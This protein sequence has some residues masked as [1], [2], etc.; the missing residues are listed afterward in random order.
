M[1]LSELSPGASLPKMELQAGRQGYLLCVE[2]SVQLT[3]ADGKVQRLQQ[4]DAAELTGPLCLQP[5]AEK[6]AMLLLFEMEQTHR[7]Y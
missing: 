5:K 2:G 1:F 4:H 3:D 6:A 7:G